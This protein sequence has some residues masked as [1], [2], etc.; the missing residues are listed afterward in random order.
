MSAWELNQTCFKR[1]VHNNRQQERPELVVI[2]TVTLLW[3]PQCLLCRFLILRDWFWQRLL[4]T[5]VS[6][7]RYVKPAVYDHWPFNRLGSL[8]L[9]VDPPVDL[10]LMRWDFFLPPKP[11]PP[12]PFIFFLL[13][14]WNPNEGMGS[15]KSSTSGQAGKHKSINS[16]KHLKTLASYMYTKR[17]NM[18]L[19]TSNI[20]LLCG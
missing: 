10:F 13:C 5:K 2:I 11:P 14:G 15:L 19:D 3:P 6:G 16:W 20:C 17:K 7:I 8:K 12:H 1:L 9:L 4:W 18:F